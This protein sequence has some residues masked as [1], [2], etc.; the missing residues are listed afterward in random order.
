LI[1]D[2]TDFSKIQLQHFEINNSWFSFESVVD[3]V[4]D[5]LN[6]SVQGKKVKIVKNLDKLKN[7]EIFSDRKRVK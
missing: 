1:E 3:E 7:I 5:M 2:I 4:L 6:F